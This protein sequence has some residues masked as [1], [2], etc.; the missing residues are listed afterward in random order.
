[1]RRK[2]C[3]LRSPRRR[4]VVKFTF[5]L[6]AAGLAFKSSLLKLREAIADQ[7]PSPFQAESFEQ[8]VATIVGSNSIVESDRIQIDMVDLAEDGAIVPIKVHAKLPKVE[9]IT[10][11]SEKNPVPLIAT[12]K[13][14]ASI[15]EGYVSTRI[16]LAES[17]N[18]H[19]LV[20]ADGQYFRGKKFV[21]VTKGGCG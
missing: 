15:V 20:K 11:I 14:G 2:S 7:L 5:A 10:L 8:A 4:R 12:F 17:T 16:K 13:L 9:Q 6:A 19:A 18:V 1:M 21:V 3:D